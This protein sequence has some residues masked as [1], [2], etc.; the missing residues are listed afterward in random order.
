MKRLLPE[1]ARL[2]RFPMSAIRLL[3]G[4]NRTSRQ[5]QNEANDPN[6]WSGRA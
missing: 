4:A 5:S 2:D 6:V 1:L 3:L